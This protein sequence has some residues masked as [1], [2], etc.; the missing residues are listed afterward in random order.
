MRTISCRCCRSLIMGT[1][2]FDG[3]DC[4]P[5][6]A[7]W[8]SRQWDAAIPLQAL[9]VRPPDNTPVAQPPS[10][11]GLTWAR[12]PSAAGLT[13]AQPP[14]ATGPTWAQPPSATSLTWA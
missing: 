13:W 6:V 8:Y 3:E 14:P 9:P 12:P 7:V 11:A 2:E 4:G 10:A 1:C 5:D